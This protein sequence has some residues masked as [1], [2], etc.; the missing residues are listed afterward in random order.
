VA[1]RTRDEDNIKRLKESTEEL[2]S[3]ADAMSHQL[4]QRKEKF[5][6]RIFETKSKIKALVQAIEHVNSECDHEI[7]V[8]M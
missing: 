4:N 2:S 8:M 7:D 5:D 6:K 3:K 1:D